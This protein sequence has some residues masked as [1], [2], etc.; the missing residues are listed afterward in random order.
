MFH[1]SKNGTSWRFP[2][3]YLMRLRMVKYITL[4]IIAINII[5]M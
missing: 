3:N 2:Y 5:F 1:F 4:I